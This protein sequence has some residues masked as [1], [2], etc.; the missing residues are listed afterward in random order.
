MPERGAYKGVGVSR[1]PTH[2][3]EPTVV[4]TGEVYLRLQHLAGLVFTAVDEGRISAPEVERRLKSMAER[5][6]VS[7]APAPA[8]AP[9]AS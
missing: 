4:V 1:K 9:P 3:L 5:G 8:D 2:S 6:K 7:S